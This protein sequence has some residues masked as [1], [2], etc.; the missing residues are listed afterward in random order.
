[1]EGQGAVAQLGGKNMGSL[2]RHS[3]PRGLYELRISYSIFLSLG[4]FISKTEE[5]TTTLHNCEKSVILFMEHG[6]SARQIFR[7]H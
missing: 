7:A 3:I 2:V 6:Q 1:M 5:G 4:S